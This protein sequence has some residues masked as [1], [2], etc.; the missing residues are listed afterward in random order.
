MGSSPHST[1]PEIIR[2]NAHEAHHHVMDINRGH[3]PPL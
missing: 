2:R 1:A 3:E